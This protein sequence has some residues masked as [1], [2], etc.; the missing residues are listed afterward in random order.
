MLCHRVKTVFNILF[1]VVGDARDI[2]L[3]VLEVSVVA[4]S[5]FDFFF[6]SPKHFMQGSWLVA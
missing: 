1:R 5:E 6:P 4:K 3:K 2:N